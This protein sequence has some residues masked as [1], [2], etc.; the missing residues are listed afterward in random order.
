M[1]QEPISQ[2]AV[3]GL[4]SLV[5]RLLLPLSLYYLIWRGL[6]QREYL[7]RWSEGEYAHAGLKRRLR[8]RPRGRGGLVMIGR[9]LDHYRI[10]AKLGE[11]GLER[12][13][14][15]LLINARDATPEMLLELMKTHGVAKTVIIQVIHYRY[16]NSYLADV[17]KQY[18]LP[19]WRVVLGELLAPA[20]VVGAHDGHQF[21]V[22]P[23]G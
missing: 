22:V 14:A 5:I 3:R 6:R 7:D 15:N 18:P 10:E 4:Y 23:V 8:K 11:A 2:R 12:V 21:G 20:L 13:L 1:P 17:L 19:G 9:T 16:D